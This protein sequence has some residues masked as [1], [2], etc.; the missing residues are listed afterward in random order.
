MKAGFAVSDI[1]PELGIYLTGY[2][3]PERLAEGVHSPLRA[4]AMVLADD[5]T[6]IAVVSLDWCGMPT[7]LA[8]DMRRGIS[9]AAGIPFDHII[10]CCT[11]THSAPITSTRRTLSRTD[12]D[13][14]NRGV[15]YA[16][17]SLPV[18]A[19]TVR[20]A[21]D[22]M[23]EAVAGFGVTTSHT[24]V[25]RRGMDENGN[26]TRFIADPHQICD[27]NLTAVRFLDRATG[28]DLGI[29]LHLGCHNTSMGLSRLIS[30]DWCGVMRE[31]VNDS[32]HT[33]VMFVNGAFGDI[34]PN[35][36]RMIR[37]EG[38]F[39]YSAGAGDGERSAQEVGL[40]AA[41]DALRALAGI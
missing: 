30:S 24:G 1:T 23:R 41:N 29:L 12:I 2:G 18:I 22:G 6:E 3:H 35:T 5:R 26:V 9:D 31:R 10:V 40:R 38:V 33:T 11:H 37:A 39:G 25:S 13:P 4:T 34:G 15:A 21:K 19:D 27:D 28:E 32:Y 8:D 7:E 16:R 14:E 36:R 17:K 20:R